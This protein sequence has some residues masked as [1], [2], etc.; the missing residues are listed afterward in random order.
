MEEANVKAIKWLLG[1]VF[2]IPAYQRGYRWGM[3]ETTELLT[4]VNAFSESERSKDA[5]YCLQPIVVK[6]M[7]TARI[8]ASGLDGLKDCYEVID[9]Q[10][11]LT[12][13]LLI[14]KDIVAY[15]ARTNEYAIQ[16][17]MD[18]QLFSIHYETRSGSSAFLCKSIA[19]MDAAANAS[20]D[21][22]YMYQAALAVKSWFSNTETRPKRRSIFNADL[23]NNVNVI[24]YEVDEAEDSI[25]AFTR[26][27]INKIKLTNSELVKALFLNRSNFGTQNEDLIRV[28]QLEISTE[29]DTI[30]RDLHNEELWGFVTS[31]KSSD[32]PCRI[33]YILD[34]ISGKQE[35]SR[36]NHTFKYFY[37]SSKKM[38][39]FETWLLIKRY[40]QTIKDWF[41]D[42][43]LYHKVGYLLAIKDDISVLIKMWNEDRANFDFNL[44][45]RIIERAGGQDVLENVAQLTYGDGVKRI[46]L[47]HNVLTICENENYS[48]RFSFAKYVADK[49]DVEHIHASAD[50]IEDEEMRKAWLSEAKDF[51]I[52]DTVYADIEQYLDS[53]ME[54]DP[55]V[56]ANLYDKVVSKL[57]SG[58]DGIQNL[59]LLDCGT[60]RGYKAAVYPVKRTKIL[61]KM[62]NGQFI[63]SCTLNVFNKLYSTC[64]EDMKVW[65]ESAQ[66]DYVHSMQETFSNFLNS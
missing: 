32:Y 1:K 8:K 52:G 35:I 64:V 45:A 42:K 9:G 17:C 54:Q 20:I 53:A 41:N 57:G 56:F 61:E 26:L 50:G 27:N 46:L 30:E 11:R 34:L 23:L 25:S 10:Q 5:F 15:E 49:W 59:C 14:L 62:K 37:D 58:N 6:K 28:R 33:E 7:N 40:Y 4:D 29:W 13:L 31:E 48:A 38:N 66:A 36:E 24:W 3:D 19:E 43:A 55:D 51:V 2:F 65:G 21:Y 39:V 12:T 47:L 44:K 18:D 60:N 63:P 22:H 16:Q